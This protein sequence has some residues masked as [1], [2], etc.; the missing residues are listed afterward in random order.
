[1]SRYTNTIIV[2]N[3]SDFYS[4]LAQKRGLKSIQQINTV[5]L[6]NPEI[7]ERI[8]LA[9]D[10]HIWKYGDRF[11]KLA[12]TYYDDPQLWW[13]IAWYNGYPTEANVKIGDTLDIPLNLEE[14]IRV[15]EV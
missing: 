11:Y 9:T 10:T 7:F 12:H 14:I 15:L 6:K 5:V 1:M 13:I 3:D 8:G 4:S 2:N